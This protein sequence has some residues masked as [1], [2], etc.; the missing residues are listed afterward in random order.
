MWDW[1]SRP[2]SWHD[3]ANVPL[4]R[5]VLTMIAAGVLMGMVFFVLYAV[6]APLIFAKV[7]S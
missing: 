4:R 1:Y 6:L 3:R 7:P 5:L 2:G